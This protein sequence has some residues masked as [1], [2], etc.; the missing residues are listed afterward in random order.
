MGN[1]VCEKC[2]RSFKEKKNFKHHIDN[3]VCQKIE[4]QFIC[5]KCGKIFRGKYGFDYHVQKNVCKD[6]TRTNDNNVCEHCNKQYSSYSALWTHKGKWC[7]AKIQKEDNT[8]RHLEE[9]VKIMQDEMNRM[10]LA[11][12]TTI[13]NNTINNN[14]NN[15]N[16]TINVNFLVKFGKED[17]SKLTMNDMHNILNYGFYAVNALVKKM[18]FD[19]NTPENHNVCFNNLKD[20]YGT[21]FDGTEWVTKNKSE[22]IDTLIDDKRFIIEESLNTKA[23]KK[24]DVLKQKAVTRMMEF[25]LDNEYI[26]K[27]KEEL[28]LMMY[29][30]RKYPQAAIKKYLRAL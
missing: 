3:E 28:R 4:A 24:L 2:D 7:K 30:N 1:Y 5:P 25:D 27:T 12:E 10:R 23:Y 11:M 8:Q 6:N 22:I 21:I 19:P 18:H 9:Q 29:D 15:S 20:K 26:I 13:V 14:I 17:T 16:N